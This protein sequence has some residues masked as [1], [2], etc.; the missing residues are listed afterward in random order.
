MRHSLGKWRLVCDTCREGAPCGLVC[1]VW[2][3]AAT[4]DLNPRLAFFLLRLLLPPPSSYDFSTTRN[5]LFIFS[6]GGCA[7][8]RGRCVQPRPPA[9]KDKAARAEVCESKG[10]GLRSPTTRTARTAAMRR[11]LG[12][13]VCAQACAGMSFI[14]LTVSCRSSRCSLSVNCTTLHGF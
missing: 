1:A 9:K 14:I 13:C 5:L 2:W 7:R 3:C 8:S 11:G 6:P 4:L 10:T 12:V